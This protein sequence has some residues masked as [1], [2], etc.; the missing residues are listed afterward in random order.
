MEDFYFK[1]KKFIPDIIKCFPNSL[2]IFANYLKQK[3]YCGIYP[4]AVSCTGENLYDEQ[5]KL[6]KEVFQC[7]VF[8]KFGC[9]ES[10]VVFCECSEHNGLHTFTEG[11]YVEYLTDGKK[12]KTR[13]DSRYYNY[14]FV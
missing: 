9:F 2:T 4:K 1:L 11:T 7:P 12:V 5:K 13:R 3:G 8:E 6:F 10:G 14:R